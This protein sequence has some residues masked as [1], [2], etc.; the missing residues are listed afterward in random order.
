MKSPPCAICSKACRKN[1]T[2]FNCWGC[3]HLTHQKCTNY[4]ASQ[5]NEMTA[6]NKPKPFYC[7][8]CIARSANISVVFDA[9]IKDKR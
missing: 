4:T 7:R 5:H 9:G 1:Q 3:H 2:I 6:S 8:F